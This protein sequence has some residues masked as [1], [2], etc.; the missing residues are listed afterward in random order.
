MNTKRAFTLAEIIIAIAVIGVLAA[1]LIIVIPRVVDN[2][3]QNSALLDAENSLKMLCTDDPSF[4]NEDMVICVSKA[5][6]RLYIWVY[7]RGIGYI[8]CFK[9]KLQHK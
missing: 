4:A 3:N 8:P 9:A 7:K 2:A 6:K 5:K 1:I